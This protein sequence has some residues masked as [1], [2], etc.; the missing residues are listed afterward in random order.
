MDVT[1]PFDDRARRRPR[2]RVSPRVLGRPQVL[3]ARHCSLCVHLTALTHHYVASAGNGREQGA[4]TLGQSIPRADVG[5]NDG[6]EGP[7]R[8]IGPRALDVVAVAAALPRRVQEGKLP[9]PSDEARL[10]RS[11]L[12][13]AGRT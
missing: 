11:V 3:D 6:G 4:G 8:G 12:R 13:R 10:I 9:R 1:G 7:E 5:A 2:T